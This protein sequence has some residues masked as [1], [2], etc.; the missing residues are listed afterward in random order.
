M[1]VGKQE[2]KPRKVFT[3]NVCDHAKCYEEV[4]SQLSFIPRAP[5]MIGAKM[6][7]TE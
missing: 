6:M 5:A 7:L 4:C 1:P 2:R 3:Y